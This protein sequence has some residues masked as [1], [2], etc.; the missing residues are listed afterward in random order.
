[1]YENMHH[2]TLSLS[3]GIPYPVRSRHYAGHG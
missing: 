3:G 1:M 2:F